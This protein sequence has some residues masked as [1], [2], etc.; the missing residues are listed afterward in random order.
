MADGVRKAVEHVA[1]TPEAAQAPQAAQP[2]QAPLA[3][4]NVVAEPDYVCK[5]KKHKT[6]S[7]YIVVEDT[8]F[9]NLCI[10]DFFLRHLLKPMTK[11]AT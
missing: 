8:A 4:Q 6:G 7:A 11:K 1:A 5:N 9:C 2:P 10:R 3:I